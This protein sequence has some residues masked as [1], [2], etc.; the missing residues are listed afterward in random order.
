[1]VEDPLYKH[2]DASIAEP[3]ANVLGKFMA[4]A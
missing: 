4:I 2:I 3:L 1:M